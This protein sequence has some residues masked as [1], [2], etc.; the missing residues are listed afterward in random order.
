MVVLGNL[1]PLYGVLVW[2]WSLFDV[3]YLYWAENLI[4]GILTI[5]RMLLSGASWGWVIL[6]GSLF[7]IGFFTFHYGM[8][9]FGHGMIMFELF[10]DGTLDISEELLLSYA[11]T[12]DDAFLYALS[13][14]MVAVLMQTLK[15]IREDRKNARTPHGIMFRPYVRILIL[16]AAIIIG[17]LLAQELGAPIWA[18]GF[19]IVLK[20]LYD[21]AV[22]RGFNDKENDENDGK[23]A[24]AE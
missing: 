15:A 24:V 14:L 1:I 12:K 17:G 8:F 2:E 10:Y 23:D 3:F 21:L 22:L 19:L 5:V 7:H 13:G 4:I 11:F 6:L 16:H 9:T 20:T 18:L